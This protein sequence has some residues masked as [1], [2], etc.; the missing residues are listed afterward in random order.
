MTAGA[1]KAK[2]FATAACGSLGWHASC[3]ACNWTQQPDPRRYY[4]DAASA[5]RQHNVELHLG[6][7][8]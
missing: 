6:A 2:G 8:R 1:A 4:S 3:A 7:S 5:A